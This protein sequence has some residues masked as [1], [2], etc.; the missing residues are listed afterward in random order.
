L[1]YIAF[2]LGESG[3]GFGAIRLRLIL[4]LL[5]KCKKNVVKENEAMLACVTSN[6]QTIWTLNKDTPSVLI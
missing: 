3:Y 5:M 1:A 6:M 2:C 4:S